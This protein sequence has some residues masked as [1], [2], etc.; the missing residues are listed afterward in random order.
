MRPATSGRS[1][2]AVP[3][4]AMRWASAEHRLRAREPVG[5]VRQQRRERLPRRHAVAGLR[6]QEHARA[7]L[8]GIAL[9][10]AAGPEAPGGD[11]DGLRVLLDEHPVRLGRDHG[12]LAGF[13]QRRIRVAALRGDHPPPDVHGAAVVE[14]RGRIGVGQ[15]REREHLARRAPR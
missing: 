10:G 6:V 8:H 1:G 4:G 7:V 13:G 12:A 5:L 15:P 2:T 9:A 11:A 3:A 14:R